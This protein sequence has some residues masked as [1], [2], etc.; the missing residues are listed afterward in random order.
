MDP[1][2][3]I[4]KYPDVKGNQK[5]MIRYCEKFRQDM[6]MLAKHALDRI[7]KLIEASSEMDVFLQAHFIARVNKAKAKR[8]ARKLARLKAK[9]AAKRKKKHGKRTK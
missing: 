6:L 2:M 3:P 4:L 8:E 9:K 7:N 1:S 5:E